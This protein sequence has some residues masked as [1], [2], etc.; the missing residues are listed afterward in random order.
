MFCSNCGKELKEGENFCSNCGKSI[1]NTNNINKT[2]LEEDD[3]TIAKR[4]SVASI[5]MKVIGMTFLFEV[6]AF[7]SFSIPMMTTILGLGIAA[8]II[9]WFIRPIIGKCPYCGSI[10][11]S[12][13]YA[14][15]ICPRCRKNVAVKDNK[16][17]KIRE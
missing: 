15:F 4:E 3:Y 2:V 9:S 5:S 17:M 6:I 12:Y 13:N 7:M 10:V 16:F 8:L 1:N 14:G 11:K